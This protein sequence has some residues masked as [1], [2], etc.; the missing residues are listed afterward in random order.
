MKKILLGIISFLLFTNYIYANEDY[1][2]N[3]QNIK[4]NK[5]RI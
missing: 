4:N 3:K 1:I 2:I 5:A